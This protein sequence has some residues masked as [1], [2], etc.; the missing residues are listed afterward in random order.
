MDSAANSGGA[1]EFFAQK[2]R[3]KQAQWNLAAYSRLGVQR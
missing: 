1:Y 2:Y 3:V